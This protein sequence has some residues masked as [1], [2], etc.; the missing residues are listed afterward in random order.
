MKRE[1]V[2]QQAATLINGDRAKDYGDASENFS[3]IGKIWGAIL[4]T[5]DVPPETVAVMLV[6]LKVSRL[7]TSRKHADSW[8]DIAGYAGLGGEI[9]SCDS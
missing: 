3:R 7:A 4:G 2:L 5:E 6:G 1:D 8:V 9:A